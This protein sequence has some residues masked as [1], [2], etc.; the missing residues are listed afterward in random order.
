MDLLNKAYA[1]ASDSDEDGG[2]GRQDGGGGVPEQWCPLPPPPKRLR[3]EKLSTSQIQMATFPPPSHH[4]DAPIP[5][6]YISKRQRAATLNPTPTAGNRSYVAPSPGNSLK[7]SVSVTD[8]PRAILTTLQR[9]TKAS[10]NLVSLSAALNGHTSSVNAVQW[11]TTHAHL[12]ASAGMDHTVNIWNVWSGGQ[13]RACTFDY[14]HAAVKDVKWSHLGLSVLSCGYDCTSRLVDVEK[15]KEIKVFKEDQI[16][17]VVKFSPNNYDLFISG[18]SKGYLKLWDIRT[19]T[20]VHEY[21]RSLGPILDVEFTVDG[22]Q[23]M[24]SS[25]VSKSNISE[26]SIIVWDVS[27]Q[28]PLSNQVY[29]EAYTCPSI[30]CHPFEPYFIAQSHGNYIAIFSSR[31]PFKLDKYKRYEGHGVCGFPIKCNFS[32]DGNLVVSGSSDGCIYFYNSKTSKLLSKVKAYEQAC[33]DVVF[34]PALPNVVASCSWK[35]EVSVLHKDS[36]NNWKVS[37]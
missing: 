9:R 23:L 7:G 22:M 20:V 8:V 21:V 35:G 30:R 13:K 3:P 15:G 33:I 16:V 5:G 25:D 26:N 18:G 24:T 27:R 1:T 31:P 14:H 6:R 12:L 11:S 10:Q 17:Q 19:G 28:V 4:A 2:A 36:N 29:A 32:L 34:H 37:P